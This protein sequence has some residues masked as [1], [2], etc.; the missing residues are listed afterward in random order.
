MNAIK[1][2]TFP[3]SRGVKSKKPGWRRTMRSLRRLDHDERYSPVLCIAT[4]LIVGLLVK[5]GV[6]ARPAADVDLYKTKI[7]TLPSRTAVPDSK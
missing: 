3:T 4:L 7:E 2:E 5:S 6:L 1:R